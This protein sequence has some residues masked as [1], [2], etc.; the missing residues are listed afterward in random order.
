MGR[1][2]W[3]K[4]SSKLG[5]RYIINCRVEDEPFRQTLKLA[6]YARIKE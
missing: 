1:G 4:R 6:E 2:E 5:Y 3:W